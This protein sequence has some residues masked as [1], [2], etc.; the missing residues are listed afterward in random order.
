MIIWPDDLIFYKF[1]TLK[2]IALNA[3][4][5]LIDIVDTLVIL[6]EVLNGVDAELIK[7]I[8]EQPHKIK[9]LAKLRSFNKM[10]FHNN[11]N[12]VGR[13]IMAKVM[14]TFCKKMRKNDVFLLSEKTKE[15]HHS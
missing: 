7:K 5:L 2:K 8:K 12:R 11:K 13:E 9:S 10:I 6:V 14:V 1:I 3:E 15:N 4:M